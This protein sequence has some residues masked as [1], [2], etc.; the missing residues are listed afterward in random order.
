MPVGWDIDAL[1]AAFTWGYERPN[2]TAGEKSMP[3]RRAFAHRCFNE[4]DFTGGVYLFYFPYRGAG[5]K[6]V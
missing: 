3:A 5:D 1:T 2:Q 4:L 6:W